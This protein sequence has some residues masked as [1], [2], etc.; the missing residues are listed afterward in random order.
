MG[1]E[2]EGKKMNQDRAASNDEAVPCSNGC[3]F[4]GRA[5][6]GNMCSRCYKESLAVLAQE[7]SS[8]PSSS[9]APQTTSTSVLSSSSRSGLEDRV[10]PVDL[11]SNKR[12][13]MEAAMESPV[14]ERVGA[15]ASAAGPTLSPCA[16]PAASPAVAKAPSES[17][18]AAAAAV[19]T[20]DRSRCAECKKKV[21]LTGIE[22][23]CGKVY[24]GAHRMAEKHACTFD[25][26]T[27]GRQNIEKQNERVVAQSLVDKL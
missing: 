14:R 23:R 5:S 11:E 10:S 19:T 9:E 4:F 7:K 26:K 12:L 2:E 1:D 24:C 17:A 25:F 13:R 15:C 8:S 3:G 21:G 22:C 16:S 18:A 6:T 27:F 20:V